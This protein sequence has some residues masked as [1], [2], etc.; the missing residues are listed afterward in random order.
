ML[1]GMPLS[2]QDIEDFDQE[3]YNSLKWLLENKDVENI[4]MYF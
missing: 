1:L 2:Y 4:G 3:L